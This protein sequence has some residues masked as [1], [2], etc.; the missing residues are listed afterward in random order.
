MP[1]VIIRFCETTNLRFGFPVYPERHL[2]IP[3]ASGPVSFAGFSP[4]GGG[5]G[6]SELGVPGHA[7]SPA[8][9]TLLASPPSLLTVMSTSGEGE[10]GRRRRRKQ[11]KWKNRLFNF[12][13]NF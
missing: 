7:P 4:G 8:P 6:R 5:G 9:S 11:Q 2:G 12:T 13:I 10:E 3:P 1:S